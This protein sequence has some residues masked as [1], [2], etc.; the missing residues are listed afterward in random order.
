[1]HSGGIFISTGRRRSARIGTPASYGCIRMRSADVIQLY[2]TVGV[3]AKVDITMETIGQ[4]TGIAEPGG[5][6]GTAMAEGGAV[7]KAV[8]VAQ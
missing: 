2:D 7:P 1:M 4:A 5:A 3:G 6:G 8:A